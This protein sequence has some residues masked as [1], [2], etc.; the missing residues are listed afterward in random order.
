MASK[1]SLMTDQDLMLYLKQG[2]ALAFDEL[3]LRYSKRLLGYFIRMLNFD[4]EKA[5]DSLHDVFLKVIEKPELFDRTKSFKTWVYTIAYNTCKNHYKHA[6]IVKQAH[7]ELKSTEDVLDEKFFI[8]MAAR[9]DALEFKKALNDVLSL[10]SEDK[11]TTF[12]LRY[13][14]DN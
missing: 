9:M 13:Q 11:R 12:I 8:T 2:E 6:G 7:D 5:Q 14:E 10:M 3:Y 4:K 1:Y